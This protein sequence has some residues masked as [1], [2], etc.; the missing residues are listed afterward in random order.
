MSDPHVFG[1]GHPP[2]L[3]ELELAQSQVL[4]IGD[5]PSAEDR[6]AGDRLTGWR[7]GLLVLVTG[8]HGG[9]A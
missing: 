8:R 3:P 7:P 1:D 9:R 2:E 5:A 4:V 6:R